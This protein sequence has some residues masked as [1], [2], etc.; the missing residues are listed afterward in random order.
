MRQA[1]LIRRLEQARSKRPMNLYGRIYDLFTNFFNIQ[2]KTPCIIPSCC[3][4]T[5]RSRI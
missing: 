1:K 4:A 3:K 5:N 2:G